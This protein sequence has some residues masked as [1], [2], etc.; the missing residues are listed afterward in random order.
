MSAKIFTF[1]IQ[2][3]AGKQANM[4]VVRDHL[5]Q[6]GRSQDCADFVVERVGAIFDYYECGK[7][8]SVARLDGEDHARAERIAL[9]L[10]E[11][12]SPMMSGLISELVIAYTLIWE[13]EGG[14]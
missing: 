3:R 5:I 6:M 10:E 4:T 7:P 13:L 8:L 2:N 9:E 11:Q 12:I 14:E 1:E